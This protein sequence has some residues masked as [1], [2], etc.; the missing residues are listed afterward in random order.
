MIAIS[1]AHGR[2]IRC[3]GLEMVYCIRYIVTS[4]V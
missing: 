3:V 2:R 1:G 4:L